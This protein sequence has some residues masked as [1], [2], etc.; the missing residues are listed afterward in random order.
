MEVKF[1]YFPARVD[2]TSPLGAITLTQFVEI[3]KNPKPHIKKVLEEISEASKVGDEKKKTELKQENLYYFVFPVLLSRGR[4][5][6]NISEFTGLMGAEF[7]KVDY[8]QDLR[9]Y[10]FEKYDSCLV[11]WVTPSKKGCKFLFKIPKVETI[12]QYKEYYFGLASELA[13]F[14]GFDDSYQNCVL[15]TFISYDPN[16]KSREYDLANTWTCRGYKE[17][18]FDESKVDLDLIGSVEPT[19]MEQRRIK[20]LIHNLIVNIE[21]NGHGTVI[22]VSKLAGGYCSAGYYDEDE[23]WAILEEAIY[24]SPYL[25]KSVHLYLSTSQRYFYEGMNAPLILK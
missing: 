9:D 8:A 17:G 12:E 1:Q 5:Y 2:A 7:D 24:E 23:M 3:T 10:I 6:A 20:D 25:S 13:E 14:Q 19:T 16:I 18:S 4:S 11:A 21:D 15:P 22:R